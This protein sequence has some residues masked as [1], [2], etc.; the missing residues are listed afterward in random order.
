MFQGLE[1]LLSSLEPVTDS[2]KRK[3]ADSNMRV[4]KKAGT[5]ASLQQTSTFPDG[6][7]SGAATAGWPER[8]FDM[9]PSDNVQN[10]LNQPNLDDWQLRDIDMRQS[11]AKDSLNQ[12][13]RSGNQERYESILSPLNRPAVSST[14]GTSIDT[15][16][17][18]PS[19]TWHLLDVY[20]SYTHS[21]LPIIEK[22]DLLRISYQYSQNRGNLSGSGSGD[23]AALWAAIAY[24]KF[25][26]R[27]INNIPRALGSVGEMV[28]TAERMYSQ[29]RCLIPN[30]EGTL[31]LGHVQALLIL[32]LAN[33]GMGYLSRAWLL[34]GQAVRAAIDLQLDQALEH[35]LT[36]SKSKSRAKHV[37]LGCFVLDT[38]ISA[39]LGH[40]PHL[41]S[42]DID[43]V[44]LL[45]EDGLEEWDPWTDCLNVRRSSSG[46]SRGPA[47]ILSTFNRLVQVLRILN[48][49]SCSAE[50]SNSLQLSTSLLEKLHIWSQSQSP[51]LYYN[52]N[53]MDSERA[54]SLLPHQ[55]HLHT[56]Y[57]NTLT[58]SQ[59]ISSRQG[60]ENVNLEPCTRSA[61]HITE[62]LNRH[63]NIFGLLIVPPTYEYYV[64]TAYDV[65][66]AV[67]SSIENT[68]IVLNDWKRS[69]D[70]C[71]ETME[72]AWPVFEA[73]KNS[74]S[75][76]STTQPRRQ[77]EV[78]FDLITGINQEVAA[79]PMVGKTPQT[80]T[81]YEMMSQTSPHPFESRISESSQHPQ[82]RGKVTDPQFSQRT[83]AFGQPSGHGLPQNP[84]NIYEDAH[85]TFGSTH[86]HPSQ[87]HRLSQSSMDM[88]QQIHPRLQHAMSIGS[89]VDMS[90]DP[91]F[92]ELMRLDATEW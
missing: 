3:R 40:R 16:P 23:H 82:S 59:L 9:R 49:A 28:W 73:F 81:S 20:F 60:Q 14:P 78:A 41:R 37:F 84:L 29:A 8:N 11:S 69:L 90:S 80:V 89:D 71:L 42:E 39:R 35:I 76:Q 70:N 34:I 25:Q 19:E 72:P 50:G 54:L 87:M 68:H 83:S 44:G 52:S 21:W 67:N 66:N 86:K 13:N 75:Y 30:E 43:T 55:Y 53:A 57:F 51:P 77:S 79:S 62:L 92:H 47:T 64:K 32:T 17:D 91:T 48:E 88:T 4:S 6:A 26:H 36:S 18:L 65:V 22:H 31:E 56:V 38:I 63:S 45:E 2:G 61:C 7:E 58:A 27:A 15:I 85:A 46:N 10:L 24:A 33:L 1:R 12:Q 5:R 74:V